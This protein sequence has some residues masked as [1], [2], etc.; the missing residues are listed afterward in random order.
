MLGF[1]S[2]GVIVNSAI[3]ELPSGNNGKVLPFALG[4]FLYALLLIQLRA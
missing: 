2:G 3:A 4:S 1:L